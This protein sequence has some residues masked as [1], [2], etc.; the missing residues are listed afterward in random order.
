MNYLFVWLGIV[1]NHNSLVFKDYLSFKHIYFYD[2]YNK[3]S[4]DVAMSPQML[5]A[6]VI[7]GGKLC[8]NFKEIWKCYLNSQPLSSMKP[9]IKIYLFKIPF[10]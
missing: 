5:I 1:S 8:I 7:R 2:N 3:K 4:H 9:S 6:I 10:F